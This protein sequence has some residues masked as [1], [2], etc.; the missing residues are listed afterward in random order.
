[1]LFCGACTSSDDRDASATSPPATSSTGSASSPEPEVRL[2]AS[3]VQQR[4]DE[5]TNTIDVR[6]INRGR[7]LVRV[8]KVHI[9]WSG[10]TQAST[11]GTGTDYQ[12]GRIIDIKTDYG[13]PVCGEEPSGEVRVEV[14]LSDDRVTLPVDPSGAATLRRLFVEDCALRA[15]AAIADIELSSPFTRATGGGDRLLGSVEVTRTP[16]SRSGDRGELIVEQI[17]GSILFE[18]TYLGEQR[19]PNR[20]RADDDSLTLPVALQVGNRCDAHALA[21]SR[22]TFLFSVYVR[23]EGRPTQRV[24][25][26][27]DRAVRRQASVMITRVCS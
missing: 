19:L 11:S 21:E 24:I 25:V 7:T 12:P 26:A 6:L 1:M 9:V 2:R 22:Q 23:V 3:L 15:I 13:T 10:I 8:E 18:L 17:A 20:L 27:P 5:G 14:A 4:T 16:Q